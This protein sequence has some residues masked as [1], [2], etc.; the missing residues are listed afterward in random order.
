MSLFFAGGWC[1]PPP[2]AAGCLWCLLVSHLQ[3][4]YRNVNRNAGLICS[5]ILSRGRTMCFSRRVRLLL[6]VIA[7]GPA[8]VSVSAETRKPIYRIRRYCK[9]TSE[10]SPI[11]SIGLTLMLTRNFNISYVWC[12]FRLWA[13]FCVFFSKFPP[14]FSI[15]SIKTFF[16]I[17]TSFKQTVHMNSLRGAIVVFAV[18]SVYGW[19]SVAYTGRRPVPCRRHGRLRP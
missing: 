14:Y 8:G 16:Q 18:Y 4:V 3:S 10:Y 12:L 5:H 7:A 2:R 11:R 6:I 13:Y 15:V 9:S 17:C 1:P 19:I